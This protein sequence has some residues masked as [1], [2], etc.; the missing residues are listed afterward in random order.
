M[1]LLLK[2]ILIFQKMEINR[3]N[4]GGIIQSA[5]IAYCNAADYVYSQELQF[6][7][8]MD[9][10]DSWKRALLLVKE[11]NVVGIKYP[12][13]YHQVYY[14]GSSYFF[15]CYQLYVSL[16]NRQCNILL[17]LAIDSKKKD[18]A[19]KI[20]RCFCENCKIPDHYPYQIYYD[21]EDIDA[22]QAKYDEAFGEKEE[23]IEEGV[24]SSSK[25][26]KKKRRK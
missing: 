8:D 17:D 22:A 23:A 16:R 3:L 2:K 5:A 20:I 12:T 21:K 18:I 19:K 1:K 13:D 11:M 24:Q 10:E 7:A 25:E 15:K 9:E 6:L 26:S 4:W 14:N